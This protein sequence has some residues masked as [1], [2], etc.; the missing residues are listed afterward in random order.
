[1]A[2]P[3][4]VSSVHD[5]GRVAQHGGREGGREVLVDPGRRVVVPIAAGR[6]RLVEARARDV[7]IVLAV[8]FEVVELGH[9][10]GQLT[11]VGEQTLM[12]SYRF[13]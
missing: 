9:P 7:E 2:T 4:V 6:R 5:D 12:L 3:S 11:N 8:S 1:M 10:R 13:V